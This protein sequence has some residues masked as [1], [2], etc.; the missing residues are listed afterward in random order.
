MSDELSRIVDRLREEVEEH[1]DRS[2][3]EQ[4]AALLRVLRDE[5][6]TVP[7]ESLW[8][9]LI[10]L[11][12]LLSDRAGESE[13]SHLWE[14]ISS[15]AAGGTPR[16]AHEAGA[17]TPV[18]IAESAEPTARSLLGD[19]YP[20]DAPL[21]G[22]ALER[23]LKLLGSFL[24]I[25]ERHEQEYQNLNLKLRQSTMR[26]GGDT[27]IGMKRELGQRLREVLAEAVLESRDLS[28]LELRLRRFGAAPLLVYTAY[29]A[30]IQKAIES[31]RR[32]LDP[33]TLERE[34][35][36][37]SWQAYR[38]LYRGTLYALG[39]EFQAEFFEKPFLDEYLSR[40]KKI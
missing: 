24:E 38:R 40:L 17:P 7:T 27:V 5:L 29:H 18:V 33:Q 2:P 4:Q 13:A 37:G 22:A 21:E 35:G 30:G 14:S 1:A 10:K 23:L 28:D 16:V 11:R 32:L 15:L 9:L 34:H 36:K 26:G 6:G 8:P 20:A 39:P 12:R 19:A 3:I 31:M 25:L